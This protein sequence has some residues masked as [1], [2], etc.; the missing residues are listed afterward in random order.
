MA[1]GNIT[2]ADFGVKGTQLKLTLTLDHK[3]KVVFKPAWYGRDDIITGTP[4]S[5][6]DRHNAEIAAFHL[7]RILEL[8]RTPLA[9]GRRVDIH[10]DIKPVATE[11]LLNTFFE[12][13][14]QTCFYGKCLYCRGPD[15]GV[16]A[17]TAGVMEGTLVLWLPNDFKLKLHK[18]P[19]SRTYKEGVVARWMK[20]DDYC[21]KMR[22]IARF[23]KGPRLLDIIDTSIFDYLIGN[24]DRHHYETFEGYDDSMLIILDNGKSFGN[25]D[26]DERTILAPLYQ[27]CQIRASTWQRLLA[28]Q[29][30]VLSQ[31]L[32]GVLANDPIAPV[33]SQRHLDALDRRLVYILDVI[34]GCIT[35]VGMGAIVM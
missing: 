33:L 27:C 19:W 17:T 16:C 24:A 12:K 26:L 25:P 29:D 34:Q 14:G 18:H 15:D 6:R 7:G 23:S 30:D 28:L 5:G 10:R 32:A 4:Y 22:R 2:L 1:R 9:I 8:R 3:Q 31:V 35:R 20:E 13:D 21:D 11:R